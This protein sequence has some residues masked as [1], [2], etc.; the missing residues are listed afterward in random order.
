MVTRLAGWPQAVLILAGMAGAGLILARFPP[1]PPAPSAAVPGWA[2]IAG[3]MLVPAFLLLVCERMIAANPRPAA[4]S[5]PPG[6]PAARA[7]RHRAVSGRAGQRDGVRPRR[8]AYW[9]TALLAGLAAVWWRPSLPSAPSAIWFLPLPAPEAA[10]AAIGSLVAALL[11]PGAL[12]PAKMAQQIRARLGIDVGRS[13]AVTYVRTMPRPPC[14]WVW[15]CSP[16]A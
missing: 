7:G 12:R 4:G 9:H 5:A 13:W 2:G 6:D 14:C 1:L 11:Q 3:L 10:R 15:C 8:G 16:G